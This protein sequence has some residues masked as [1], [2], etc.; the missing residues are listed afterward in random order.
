MVGNRPPREIE[1]KIMCDGKGN[2]TIHLQPF[3]DEQVRCGLKEC[4]TLHE[5]SHIND[6]LSTRYRDICK[7]VKEPMIISPQ[8]NED[9]RLTEIKAHQVEI[10]CYK[11]KRK[12]CIPGCDDMLKKRLEETENR[13]R[14]WR[15]RP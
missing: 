6:F 11:A 2:V 9:L 4:I 5:M 15:L 10:A 12:E 1:N 7:N 3:T 14:N 8:H 13:L